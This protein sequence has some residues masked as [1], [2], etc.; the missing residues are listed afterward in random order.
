[1]IMQELSNARMATSVR[2]STAANTL[3]GGLARGDSALNLVLAAP[4]L[5]L[6]VPAGSGHLFD[7]TTEMIVSPA[8]NPANGFELVAGFPA[9]LRFRFTLGRALIHFGARAKMNA[10]FGDIEWSLIGEIALPG[11]FSKPVPDPPVNTFAFSGNTSNQTDELK[12]GDQ[13]TAAGPFS[14]VLDLEA[15]LRLVHDGGVALTIDLFEVS[16]TQ[17]YGGNGAVV[18]I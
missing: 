9:V 14:N 6:I 11:G 12:I 18:T 3:G 4:L 8:S 1:M 16:Q 15:R 10:P 7:L 17:Q 2:G 13:I 5:G